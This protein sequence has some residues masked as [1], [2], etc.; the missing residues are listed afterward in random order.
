[1]SDADGPYEVKIWILKR[2]EIIV[3]TEKNLKSRFF[4]YI[5]EVLPMR[6]RLLNDV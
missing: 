2:I 3:R 1:M 6:Y 4:S 5:A